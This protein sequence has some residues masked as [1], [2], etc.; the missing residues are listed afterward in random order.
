[1][2]R[3]PVSVI[4]AEVER[5]L[6]LH[7]DAA[8]TAEGIVR[9]WLPER[10]ADVTSEQMHRA[11]ALLVERGSVVRRRIADGQAVY[12]SAG[13]TAPEIQKSRGETPCP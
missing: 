12:S 3:V 1:M 6:A 4:A 2:D 9:W 7:P 13:R 5:Y 8:D 11:L 10:L